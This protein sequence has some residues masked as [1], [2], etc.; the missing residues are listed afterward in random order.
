MKKPIFII[1]VCFISLLSIC[2]QYDYITDTITYD[3]L[4]D[5]PGGIAIDENNNIHVCWYSV[6][7]QYRSR[8]LYSKKDCETGHWSW[9]EIVSDTMV[10]SR[11]PRIA[12]EK[13]TGFHI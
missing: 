2:Q 12:I 9:P 6:I 4:I 7:D 8:I 13:G 10:M 1:A 5:A 11:Y 3:T